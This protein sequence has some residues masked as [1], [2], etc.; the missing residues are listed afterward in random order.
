MTDTTLSPPVCIFQMNDFVEWWIGAAT[1]EQMRD[2]YRAEYG[3]DTFGDDD[4]LP[5]ALDEG[6]LDKL[7]FYFGP[8]DGTPTPE[9]TR[10]FREQLAVELVAGVP[11]PRMFASEEW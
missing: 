7:R 9:L 6:E 1:P 3:D 4:D 11:M 2:A 10:T 5:R 8:E